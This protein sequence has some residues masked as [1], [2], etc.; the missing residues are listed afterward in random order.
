[1]FAEPPIK[2]TVAFIDG[3][4][5]FY[6]ARNAFGH[7]YPNYDVSALA[8]AICQKQNW[9]LAQVRF[10][11][12]L[13]DAADDPVWNHF[14]TAKLAQMG[15]QGVH[16]FSRAL[17]YRNQTVR[18]PDGQTHTFLVGQEKGVDVR[19]ALDI[20]SLAYQKAYDVALIFSQDQ[21]L[22]EVADEIRPIAKQQIRWIRIACAFPSSP[23]SANRRGING[24]DWIKIDR[25]TYDACLDPRD[26][27]PKPK[28]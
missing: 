20:V 18:L 11:T 7:T 13:P 24:T 28:T 22:S 3:Q 1:M 15:R 5:L 16:V 10:Y 27:R 8:T 9:S 14:W 25:A 12:G 21:D 23:A 26:Y 6:A 2:R 19:L 4:N 17:R